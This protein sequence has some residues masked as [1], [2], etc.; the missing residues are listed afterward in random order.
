VAI[1]H[2]TTGKPVSQGEKGVV[3][4]RPPLPPGCMSTLWGDDKRFVDTY[5]SDFKGQQV[6]S[7]FDW[8]IR[9]QDGYYFILGRSDDVINVAGHRLGTREIEEAV[10]MHPNVAEC[11]VVGVSDPLKGQMPLAFAV[12]KDPAKSTTA[13]DVMQTVDK[14]L[15]A[16]ARPKDVH[17]VTLLPK[18]RS[19]KT[20]RR[21]IQALAEGRNPGD[22]TTI[23]DPNALEQIKKALHP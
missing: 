19:G 22:L 20:L 1:L 3:T 14:Q 21:A 13:A 7:T 12:L 17:F 18:T 5:F 9:D 4:I 6:Y 11:A 8:G 23:E 15:G 16:I 2:E 10:S